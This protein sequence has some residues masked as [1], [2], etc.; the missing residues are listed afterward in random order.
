MD[1]AIFTGHKNDKKELLIIEKSIAKL[2]ERLADVPVVCGKVSASEKSFPYIESHV[3][4]QM[5]D[6]KECDRI[7]DQIGDK[8]K[9]RGVLIKRI[10][11]VEEFIKDMPCGMDKEIFEMLF[12]DGMSQKEV[13]EAVGLER[14]SVSK[15]VDKY[16]LTV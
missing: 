2:K 3:T 9:R 11:N 1:K 6:P 4:V 14:S 13:G 16:L 10:K 8:E 7:K 15:R 5:A 12:L